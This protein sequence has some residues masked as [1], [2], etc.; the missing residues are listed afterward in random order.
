MEPGCGQLWPRGLHSASETG[1]QNPPPPTRLLA[2]SL[3]LFPA[4]PS[5]PSPAD[6][7]LSRVFFSIACSTL[8][9]QC[10]LWI[11]SG[12]HPPSCLLVLSSLLSLVL[13]H[14]QDPDPLFLG[15]SPDPQHGR[16]HFTPHPFIPSIKTSSVSPY[17]QTS[18][19]QPPLAG[20]PPSQAPNSCSSLLPV[21]HKAPSRWGSQRGC[22]SAG[23]PCV[24][25]TGVAVTCPAHLPVPPW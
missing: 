14:R 1:C 8:S 16:G 24:P 22:G 4:A 13:G 6:R 18:D 5:S 11:L 17:S 19:I 7:G 21:L 12:V 2:C 3:Q 10:C 20:N 23:S 9:L 25:W 15:S